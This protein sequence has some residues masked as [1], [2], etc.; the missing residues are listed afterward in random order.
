MATLIMSILSM[1]V[2]GTAMLILLND[3]SNEKKS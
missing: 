3:L 1:A 2:P